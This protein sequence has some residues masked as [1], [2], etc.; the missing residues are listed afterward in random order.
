MEAVLKTAFAKESK[1]LVVHNLTAKNPKT[2]KLYAGKEVLDYLKSM[3]VGTND[4]VLVFHSGHGGIADAKNPEK[5]HHLYIDGGEVDRWAIQQLV[6]AKKPRSLIVLT[7][8]CSAWEGRGPQSATDGGRL[9][10][11]VGPNLQTVRS[12][13]LKPVGVV[14]ITAADDGKLAIA[15]YSGANPGKAGSAFTVAMLRLWYRN[16]V[17]YT[18]WSQFFPSLRTETGK[19]SNGQHMARAFQLPH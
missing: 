5:T 2:G 17:T 4:N 8:C 7:D 10:N 16:D 19:A 13:V 12:L 9:P 15:G 14:S 18:S 1:R 6:L 3:K 11:T